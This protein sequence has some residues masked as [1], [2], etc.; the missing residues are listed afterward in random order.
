[1]TERM[2]LLDIKLKEIKVVEDRMYDLKSGKFKASLKRLK[3]KSRKLK[4]SLKKEKKLVKKI[5]KSVM[6]KQKKILR[7]LSVFDKEFTR[8][9]H[10]SLKRMLTAI[11]VSLKSYMKH[12]FFKK[13][14][15][16]F[17]SL[18]LK[19]VKGFSKNKFKN[20]EE[21]A[22]QFVKKYWVKMIII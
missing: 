12:P 16:E 14:Y 4:S 21:A 9:N 15:H 19:K 11:N 13:V 20:P 10:E 6:K 5:L 22:N 8:K 18:F 2:K 7:V 1:M 3:S 17:I